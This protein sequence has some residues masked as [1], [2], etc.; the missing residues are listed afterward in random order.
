MPADTPADLPVPGHALPGRD[1]A[2]AIP[3]AHFV[4]GHSMWPPFPGGMIQA[5]FGLGC[6]WGAERRFWELP[7]I[8]LTAA[9]YA[10]GHTPNP[11]Y[12]EVCTGRTGHNEVVRILFDPAA[13]DYEAIVSGSE[14]VMGLKAEAF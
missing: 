1:T 14:S 5:L 12:E 3:A 2:L 13:T 11:T 9:G 8:Y 10:G 4:N 6:F 7:G